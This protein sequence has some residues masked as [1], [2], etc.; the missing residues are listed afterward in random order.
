MMEIP[1]RRAGEDSEV[2]LVEREDYVGTEDVRTD[3]DGRVWMAAQVVHGDGHEDR[4]VY[5]PTAYVN[6]RA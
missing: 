6:A 1:M 2:R 4:F 3:E 5:A